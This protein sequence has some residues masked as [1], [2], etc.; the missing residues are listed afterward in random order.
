LANSGATV[1]IWN[2]IECD[3]TMGGIS[4]TDDIV[5]SQISRKCRTRC[6]VRRLRGSTADAHIVT[7]YVTTLPARLCEVIIQEVRAP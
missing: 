3:R 7:V 1:T 4:T 5:I 2:V 6:V